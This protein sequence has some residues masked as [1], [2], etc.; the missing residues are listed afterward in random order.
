MCSRRFVFHCLP[1]IAW[2]VLLFGTVRLSIAKPLVG[3]IYTDETAER[4]D[5]GNAAVRLTFDGT[6]GRWTGLFVP[7]VGG[8]TC[9]LRPGSPPWTSPST[10]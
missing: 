9:C 10:G 7:G 8:A 3:D 4:I 5:F 2:G 6:T 1:I